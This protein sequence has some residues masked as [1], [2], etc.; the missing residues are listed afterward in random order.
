MIRLCT[1]GGSPQGRATSS[2]PPA[3]RATS[4]S[5]CPPLGRIDPCA[6]RSR[7]VRTAASNGDNNYNYNKDNNN[8]N[9]CAAIQFTCERKVPYGAKLM[10]VGSSDAIGRCVLIEARQNFPALS[11]NSIRRL[12]TE[13]KWLLSVRNVSRQRVKTTWLTSTYVHRIEGIGWR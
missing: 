7:E 9:G 2:S 10:L 1:G 13:P 12:C 4:A 11:D 6:G 3:R 5:P 8:S